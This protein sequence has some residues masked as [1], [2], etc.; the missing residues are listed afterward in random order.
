MI[1][2]TID[3][4]VGLVFNAKDQVLVAK[5]GG[6]Q[7]LSGFWEFPGGKVEPDENCEQ[8]LSRELK[9]ELGIAVRVAVPFMKLVHNYPTKTV[10]LFVFIIHQWSGKL[11][12]PYGAE[13][14]PIRW[15]PLDALSSFQFP[16][17]NISIVRRLN[18]GRFIAITPE[19]ILPNAEG[20]SYLFRWIEINLQRNIR[21]FYLRLPHFSRKACEQF[22]D[23]YI[24]IYGDKRVRLLIPSGGW[25]EG[26]RDFQQLPEWVSGVHFS[27]ADLL[28]I[29][30]YSREASLVDFHKQFPSNVSLGAS[31]HN[32]E[33]L[34]FA[35]T[36]GFEYAFIS[37]V[38]RSLSHPE[39]KP[40]GWDV[41]FEMNASVWIPCYALGGLSQ[42][43]VDSA[44]QSGAL[45][46]AGISMCC[47]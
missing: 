44:V 1:I 31:C 4:A 35:E 5:R 16:E 47:L 40:I 10:R 19:N 22:V 20:K 9:E 45:G 42:S 23:E 32:L 7:H 24:S 28:K 34:K 8:A 13:G 3:V 29:Y 43:H 46:V 18:L 37:P 36:L 26:L 38:L 27:A 21:N 2:K 25:L 15:S 33:E 17:A 30:K 41:F 14:Q 12:E 11:A 39:R 6:K